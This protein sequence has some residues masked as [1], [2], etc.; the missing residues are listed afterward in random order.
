MRLTPPTIPVF[1]VSIVLAIL[2]IGDQYYHVPS[3]HG[4]IAAHRFGMVVAAYAVLAI[5]VIFTGL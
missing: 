2:A 5:G 4:F 1:L 3:V